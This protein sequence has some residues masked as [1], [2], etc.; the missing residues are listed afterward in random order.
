M[1]FEVKDS[2][3]GTR[4]AARVLSF[5]LARATKHLKM[6]N[7]FG[8]EG[9]ASKASLILGPRTPLPPCFCL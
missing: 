9:Y 2:Y 8:K 4:L 1:I 7:L 5:T 3:G 6:D